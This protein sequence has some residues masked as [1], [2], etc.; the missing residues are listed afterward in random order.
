VQ[1]VYMESICVLLLYILLYLMSQG[2]R[3]GIEHRD[4]HAV[5]YTTLTTAYC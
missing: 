3:D 2:S 4:E 5:F 1:C